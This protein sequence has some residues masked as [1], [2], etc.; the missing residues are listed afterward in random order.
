MIGARRADVVV[1]GAGFAGLSAATA[2]VHGG[3]S[4]LVLEA[5][6]RLGGRAA[7]FRDGVTGE[8]VD[9][10]QHVLFG[11]YHE[12]R[13][14]LDRIGVSDHLRLAPAL[15]VTVM[16]LGGRRTRLV[17]PPL[18]PPLNLLAGLLEW[19]ALDLRDRLAVLR[20][21]GPL[22]RARQELRGRSGRPV[23]SAEETVTDWLRRHGQTPRLRELLWEPLALAA[24]N[25]S[26]DEAAA[27]TF[28]RVLAQMTGSVPSD[29]AVALPVRPLGEFYAEPARR[30]IEAAGGSVLT[31]VAARVRRAG[32][33]WEVA[34]GGRW[35]T[36]EAVVA[37]VPWHALS[38]LFDG[39][40][41]AALAAACASADRMGS[42]PIVTVNLWLDRPVLDRPFVGL[43]GR[44]MQWVFD[45]RLVF[46]GEAAHL[47]LVS[48]GAPDVAG[49]RNGALI[50]L[51]TRELRSG[52]PEAADAVV[53][54]ATVVREPRATFSLA[55]GQPARP[56]TGTGA[57]GF[58]LAGDWIDTGLPGT[59]EGA[60]VSG[61]RAAAAVF[62]HL[63][64]AG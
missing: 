31:R 15:D 38:R 8:L 59:I 55:P 1:I 62:E 58:F 34:A 49:A 44:A 60:V 54:R 4:V 57:D 26:P 47:S 35:A 18:G 52:V 27:P 43:P 2:L 28:V 9:N 11:C 10:G 17:C 37:A 25:Q 64:R 6:G 12:T 13:R 14:F 20:L 23:A 48:S 7:S 16:T 61:H 5:A 19:E 51:A 29:S 46:G 45:K 30:Y 22:R 50:A 21:A 41:P 32:G 42:S 33:G 63:S 40:A 56:G 24:L 36:T 3:A 39:G 53:T